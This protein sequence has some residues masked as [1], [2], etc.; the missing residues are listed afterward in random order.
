MDT[1]KKL[2][3]AI[4]PDLEERLRE[5]KKTLFFDCSWAECYRFVLEEGLNALN[6]PKPQEE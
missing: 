5:I 4:P 2:S 3:L 1:T 6:A